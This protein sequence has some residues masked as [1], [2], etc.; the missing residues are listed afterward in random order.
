MKKLFLIFVLTFSIIGGVSA[1]EVETNILKLK[2]LNACWKC[3]LAGAE[4]PKANLEE[5]NL[6]G[7][8]LNGA[9]LTEALL[10]EA[11]LKG[12]FMNE[13]PLFLG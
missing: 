11:N 6:T 10:S 7:A 12:A 5:V 3:N 8:N 13:A 9:D 2:A 1:D 4:F